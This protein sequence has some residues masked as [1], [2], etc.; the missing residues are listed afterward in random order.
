MMWLDSLRAAV[1]QYPGGRPA[2]ALRLGKADEV[3][4]K[5][6][7][8]TSANHKMGLS[9]SQH[10]VEML[11]E[12]GIDVSGFKVSVD[13]A[14]LSEVNASPDA[15]LHVLAAYGCKEMSE[16]VSAVAASLTDGHISDNDRKRI[17]KEV[18]DVIGGL[19]GLLG[20]LNAQYTADNLTRSMS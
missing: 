12:Q 5:E 10:I 6:L 15:C 11:A 16:V 3:L 13:A 9:D 8:G 4:R 1:N 18:R 17:E 19:T 2:V 14:C 7:A 20:A